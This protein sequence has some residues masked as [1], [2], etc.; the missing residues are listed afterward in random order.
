[1]VGIPDDFQDEAPAKVAAF[2]DAV[3]QGASPAE[4]APPI[5]DEVDDE[6]AAR[7][8][9]Q[10]FGSPAKLLAALRQLR[11]GEVSLSSLSSLSLPPPIGDRQK[12]LWRVTLNMFNSPSPIAHRTLLIHAPDRHQAKL[13]FCEHNQI[14][15][16][17][18]AWD[19]QEVKQDGK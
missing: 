6:K 19:I 16:M 5:A 13:I 4:A 1:L 9:M 7:E 10:E 12:K 3:E 11:G 8:L 14:A 15:D 18:H 17:T 2:A